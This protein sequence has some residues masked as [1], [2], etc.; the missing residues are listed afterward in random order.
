VNTE[1]AKEFSICLRY[2]DLPYFVRNTLRYGAEG[3]IRTPTL[4]RASAPQAGA[5]ASSATSAHGKVV[6]S[7]EL[8]DSHR[9]RFADQLRYWQPMLAALFLRGPGKGRRGL[10]RHM[11]QY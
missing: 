4:L 2:L 11:F 8:Q 1:Q 9:Q 7:D 6:F 3:G 10:R 5:S